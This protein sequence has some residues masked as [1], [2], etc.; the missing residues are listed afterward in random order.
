MEAVSLLLTLVGLL[1]PHAGRVGF[2]ERTGGRCFGACPDV[3]VWAWGTDRLAW[4]A[5]AL[6]LLW[7]MLERQWWQLLMRV[8]MLHRLIRAV[9]WSLLI[10]G[11]HISLVAHHA[12]VCTISRGNAR[13]VAQLVLEFLRSLVYSSRPFRLLLVLTRSWKDIGRV[14]VGRRGSWALRRW[15]PLL[16]HRTRAVSV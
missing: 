1:L 12:Q 14:I 5:V 16:A 6:M 3:G 13:S 7:W 2:G 8:W 11:L 15:C 9:R 4:I 10:D